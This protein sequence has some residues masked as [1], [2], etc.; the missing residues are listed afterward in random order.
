MKVVSL[1]A[2]LA[3]AACKPDPTSKPAP[4][5]TPPSSSQ[6]AR[7]APGPSL[8]SQPSQPSLPQAAAGSA[9]G[10]GEDGDAAATGSGHRSRLDKDGDGLVSPEERTEAQAERAKRMHDRFDANHDG[11]LTPDEL[12]GTGSG[13][14]GPHFDDPTALDLDKDG[15]ISPQELQQGMR[16]LRMK[17]RQQ[18]EDRGSAD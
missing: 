3:L 4:A 1:V 9:A 6:P 14:R 2:V 12:S 7:R 11:K 17:R 8:P 16:E 18:Y 5:E 10:S 13:R 15:E